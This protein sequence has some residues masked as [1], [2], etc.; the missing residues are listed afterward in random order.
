MDDI[1]HVVYENDMVDL[2]IKTDPSY[3]EYVYTTRTGKRLLYVELKKAMYGCMKAARLFW[4]NLS[5]YLTQEMGFT[6]NP[7]D[8][9]VANKMINDKRCTIVWHVDDQKFCTLTRR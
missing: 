5:T 3:K 1:V 2:M 4:D 7:Y 9:C 6:I 8:S